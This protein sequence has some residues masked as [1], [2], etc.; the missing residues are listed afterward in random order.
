MKKWLR[1]AL[2]HGIA[3]GAGAIAFWY[4]QWYEVIPKAIEAIEKM[5]I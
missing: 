2:T 3:F 1:R 5:T 4:Y